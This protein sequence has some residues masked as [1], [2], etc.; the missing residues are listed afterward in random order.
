[1]SQLYKYPIV[2]RYRAIFVDMD[3]SPVNMAEVS[4]PS[5]PLVEG[6][7]LHAIEHSGSFSATSTEEGEYS[8]MMC[9]ILRYISVRQ[10]VYFFRQLQHEKHNSLVYTIH[11]MPW[12]RLETCHIYL[13]SDYTILS[14]RPKLL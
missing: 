7:F 9:C 4:I 2:R 13:S 14:T 11:H 12:L 3:S 1:M 5:F 8:V 10:Y 6:D